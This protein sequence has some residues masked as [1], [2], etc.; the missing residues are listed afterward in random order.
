MRTLIE[1]PDRY[2]WVGFLQGINPM[3]QGGNRILPRVLPQ[4]TTHF[5]RNVLSIRAGRE[6]CQFLI[7]RI[8]GLTTVYS[9]L[10][11]TDK[12]S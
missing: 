9:N 1:I 3:T 7:Q 2:A 8:L 6:D 5:R 4:L 11:N 12:C 10:I